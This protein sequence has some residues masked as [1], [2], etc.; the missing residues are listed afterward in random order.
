MVAGKNS[1]TGYSM[2]FGNP[3]A[4]CWSVQCVQAALSAGGGDRVMLGIGGRDRL[5]FVEKFYILAVM[6]F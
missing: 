4:R 6:D 5:T 2:Q 1:D 3:P